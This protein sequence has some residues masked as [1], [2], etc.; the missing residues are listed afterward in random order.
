MDF[1]IISSFELEKIKMKLLR[2]LL[3]KPLC[4]HGC[5]FL[6]G[7]YLMEEQLG[8]VVDLCLTFN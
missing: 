1:L 8:C 2:I 7:K 6:L 5:S 3:D 4:G